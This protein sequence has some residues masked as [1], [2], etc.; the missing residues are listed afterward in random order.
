MKSLSCTGAETVREQ[1][2]TKL[3][4]LNGSRPCDIEQEINF[5]IVKKIKGFFHRIF[6]MDGTD[7]KLKI[8]P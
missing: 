1:E 5:T 2:K 8:K 4:K 6:W 3:R 7:S